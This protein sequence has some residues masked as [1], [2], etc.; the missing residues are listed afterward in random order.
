MNNSWF[1]FRK[2]I[3]IRDL[4]QDFFEAKI[5]FDNIY[6]AYKKSSS[7]PFNKM[8]LW[9]GTEVKKGPLW[10]LKD[11]SHRIFRNNQLKSGLY[12][13]LFDW[14]MGSIFHEAMKLK[15]DSYQVESYKPLLE[16]EFKGHQHNKALSKIIKEYFSLIEKANHNLV[17][18]LDSIREL[19]SKALFHLR[20]IFVSCKDNF[21]LLRFLLDNKKKV[22]KVFGKNSFNH[23]VHQMVPKGIHEA[24]MK[25]AEGCAERGWYHDAQI[26]FETAQ[27]LNRKNQ[28]DLRR[29]EDLQE[30]LRL[31]I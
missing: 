13:H 14:T 1:E 20:E 31:K 24:Y 4:F 3:F 23:I 18:E 9:V 16:L 27:K 2:D 22:E 15:E 28:I 6:T 26:Y 21:L 25:A 8:D 19:F 7:V 17:E 29:I 10:N 12:E 30:R 5:Y 11:Q